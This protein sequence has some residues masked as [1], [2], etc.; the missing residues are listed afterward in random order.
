MSP[1]RHRLL[2]SPLPAVT[3]APHLLLARIAS[4]LLLA[5]LVPA[6]AT[7]A[8]PVLPESGWRVIA[9]NDLGMHC[10]DADF[11]AF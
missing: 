6:T 8:L 1:L 5:A 4:I 10:M 7:L 11:Q 2:S 3:A 9:W